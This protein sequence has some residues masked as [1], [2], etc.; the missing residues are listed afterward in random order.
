MAGDIKQG[1]GRRQHE[2]M[3][4]SQR[5]QRELCVCRF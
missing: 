4:Y 3:Q 5:E 2:I 1:I